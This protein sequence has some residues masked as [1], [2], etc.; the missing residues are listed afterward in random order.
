MLNKVMLVLGTLLLTACVTT[1]EKPAASNNPTT[2]P[3]TAAQAVKQ[4][5]PTDVT[6]V[7]DSGCRPDLKGNTEVIEVRPRMHTVGGELAGFDPCNESVRFAM[8]ANITK[9]GRAHV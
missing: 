3:A 9:I 5:T 1:T 4:S 7:T 8:P 2:V 6:V